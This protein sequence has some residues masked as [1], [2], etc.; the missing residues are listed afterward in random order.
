MG[1]STS[2]PTGLPFDP[3]E[4]DALSSEPTSDMEEGRIF[5]V[6]K[7]AYRLHDK[8]IRPAQVIVATK[9]A[10]TSSPSEGE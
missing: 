4:H 1:V 2:D 8:L 7:K 3:Q 9:P 10:E 5:R 6:F